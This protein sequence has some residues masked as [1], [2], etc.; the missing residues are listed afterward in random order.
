MGGILK[1]IIIFLTLIPTAIL[2]ANFGNDVIRVRLPQPLN[3][4]LLYIHEDITCDE[5]DLKLLSEQYRESMQATTGV[6]LDADAVDCFEKGIMLGA[7]GIALLALILALVSL[8]FHTFGLIR[9]FNE[10]IG[11]AIFKA[12]TYGWLLLIMVLLMV[13]VVICFIQAISVYADTMHCD[14]DKESIVENA[15]KLNN[16]TKL[17]TS[18]S[19]DHTDACIGGLKHLKEEAIVSGLFIFISIIPH[20]IL[21]YINYK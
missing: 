6:E 15:E 14:I 19:I 16:S 5:K 8:L 17:S 3:K 10:K 9:T 21:Y 2:S 13:G 18:D 4:G 12:L 7:R 11:T 20:A 1:L